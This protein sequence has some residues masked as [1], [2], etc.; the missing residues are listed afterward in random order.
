MTQIA[1]TQIE[2]GSN[3]DVIHTIPTAYIGKLAGILIKQADSEIR[4]QEANRKEE[5]TPVD[6]VATI[7]QCLEPLKF[8][9][10]AKVIVVNEG[11]IELSSLPQ[12]GYFIEGFQEYVFG[13][14]T[15]RRLPI[16][17]FELVYIKG[18]NVPLIEYSRHGYDHISSLDQFFNKP[19]VLV[20]SK[21]AENEPEH[22]AGE[23]RDVITRTLDTMYVGFVKPAK[24]LEKKRRYKEHSE[25]LRDELLQLAG[26]VGEIYH[27]AKEKIVYFLGSEYGSEVEETLNISTI[28]YIKKELVKLKIVK[29]RVNTPPVEDSMK[30]VDVRSGK[31]FSV[32]RIFRIGDNNA[33][34]DTGKYAVRNIENSD[35]LFTLDYNSLK[36][37]HMII[38]QGIEINQVRTEIE[39]AKERF[40]ASIADSMA[41]VLLAEASRLKI[42]IKKL[43][44]E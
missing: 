43:T 32:N 3:K 38:C 23:I 42:V 40:E 31:V 19:M 28:E 1:S 6:Y 17:E 34:V 12:R 27:I 10:W 30:V 36:Q 24:E 15:P 16:N 5:P 25:K 18:S 41:E 37:S 13:N 11:A 4:S 2:G 44:K 22:L 21:K 20:S 39:N 9:S 26:K 35:S 33:F 8:P 14:P 29:E 7:N